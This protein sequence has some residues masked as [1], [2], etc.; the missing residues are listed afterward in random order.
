VLQAPVERFGG[1]VAGAEP[2]EVGQDV[3]GPPGQGPAEAAQLGQ[4]GGDP[5]R[6]QSISVVIAARALARSGSR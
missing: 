5:S 3:T 6:R 1:A 2:I 4:R